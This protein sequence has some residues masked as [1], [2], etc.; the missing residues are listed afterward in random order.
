ML[1]DL[2]Q[3]HAIADLGVADALRRDSRTAPRNSEFDDLKP[4]V[5]RI[6]DVVRGYVQITLCG[7]EAAERNAE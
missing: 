2:L 5:G 7:V 6:G 4:V 1:L 3:L